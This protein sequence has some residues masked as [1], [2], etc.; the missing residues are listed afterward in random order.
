MHGFYTFL[1]VSKHVT[2][3]VMRK[4]QFALNSSG[5]FLSCFIVLHINGLMVIGHGLNIRLNL[6]KISR[7]HDCK[8]ALLVSRSAVSKY[9]YLCRRIL[10]SP[11]SSPFAGYLYSSKCE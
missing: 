11:R 7:S 4:L 6:N 9:M 5:N 1:Y 2:S 3:L 8:H 10:P